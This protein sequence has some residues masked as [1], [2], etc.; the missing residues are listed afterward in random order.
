MIP[1]PINDDRQFNNADG[2]AMVFDPAWRRS[3]KAGELDDQSLEE[4]IETVLSHL[5]DH[6]FVQS[7]PTQARQVAHFRVRLLDL[8]S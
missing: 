3:L 7:E 8:N 5:G 1:V 6:P 4:R 2:F